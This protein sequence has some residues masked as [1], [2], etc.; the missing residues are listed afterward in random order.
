MSPPPFFYRAMSFSARMMAGMVKYHP[1]A[2]SQRIRNLCYRILLKKTGLNCN[3][4][5]AVTIINPERLSLGTRVSIHEYT[6]IQANGD[7][8]IG[9][10][11]AIANNCTLIAS[12][13]NFQRNDIPIKLQGSTSLPIVIDDD[14]WI[15]SKVTVLG[16]VHIGK[17]AV[18]GAGA[19]VT[20]DIPAF[21]VAFGVPCR[22][23]R[24]RC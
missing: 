5:D 16:G 6:Y 14:V 12:T 19:V 23:R 3:I 11:V 22:V 4:A 1:G 2:L 20:R 15:G 21:A 17:G 7:I 8:T 10:H 13:H 9:D 24:I 18:I